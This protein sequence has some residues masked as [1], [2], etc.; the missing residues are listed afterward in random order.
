VTVLDRPDHGVDVAALAAVLLGDR[1][2]LAAVARAR[3]HLGARMRVR[4]DGILARSA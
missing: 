4:L 3:P 1:T 2:G